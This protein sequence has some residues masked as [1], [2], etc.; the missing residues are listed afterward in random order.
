MTVTEQTS[1]ITNQMSK[2]IGVFREQNKPN[3]SFVHFGKTS[4]TRL[5]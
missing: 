1:S 5:G 2:Q 4:D 3:D